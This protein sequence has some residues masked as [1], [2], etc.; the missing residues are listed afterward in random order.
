MDDLTW[1]DLKRLWL[2]ADTRAEQ[3][4]EGTKTRKL[5]SDLAEKVWSKYE[6][7]IGIRKKL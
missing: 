1:E 7:S 4:E 3:C 6:E 5:Y 2:L